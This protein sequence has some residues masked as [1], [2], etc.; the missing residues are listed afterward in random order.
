[1]SDW[2]NKK[3]KFEPKSEPKSQSYCVGSTIIFLPHSIFVSKKIGYRFLFAHEFSLGR[4]ARARSLIKG[5]ASKKRKQ[6]HGIKIEYNFEWIR[7][8]I[9]Y[10]KEKENENGRQRNQKKKKKE[11]KKNPNWN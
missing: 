5:L 1:M 11:E 2:K 7:L 3:R 4:R 8:N 9:A 6:I 10:Q